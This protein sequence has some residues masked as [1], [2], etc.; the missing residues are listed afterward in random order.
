MIHYWMLEAEME[1]LG[2]GHE[3]HIS[4]QSGIS[5]VSPRYLQSISSYL[6]SICR[7]LQSISRVSGSLLK[8]QHPPSEMAQ[9]S[10][11]FAQATDK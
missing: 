3:T 1:P 9:W 11:V 5:R 4:L 8:P 2:G 10:R 7:Y 6:Q